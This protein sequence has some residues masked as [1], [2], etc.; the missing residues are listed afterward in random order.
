M[1]VSNYA[2]EMLELYKLAA[3]DS[4]V[5]KFET[6]ESASRFRGRMNKLRQAMRKESHPLCPIAE[7]VQFKLSRSIVEEAWLITACPQDVDFLPNLHAAG[8]KIEE[9]D[10]EPAFPPTS[11]SPAPNAVVSALEDFKQKDK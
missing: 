4:I 6:Q 8:I 10:L 5:L 1:P 9:P 11:P 7:K 3:R 2:P